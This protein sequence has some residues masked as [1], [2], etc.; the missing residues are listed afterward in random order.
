M[1][2]QTYDTQINSVC[3]PFTAVSHSFDPKTLKYE[4][5]NI[6]LENSDEIAEKH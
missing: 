4:A 6:S 1:P 2:L 3:Q 5:L